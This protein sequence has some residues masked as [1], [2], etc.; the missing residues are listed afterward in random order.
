M[1]A[2]TVEPARPTT[3]GIAARSLGTAEQLQGNAN[4]RHLFEE[5]LFGEHSI[6]DS[7]FSFITGASP[8]PF[9]FWE[10][11]RFIWAYAPEWRLTR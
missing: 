3:S 9:P 10:S 6:H 4:R 1:G 5:H 8:V 11:W 7:S 2:C